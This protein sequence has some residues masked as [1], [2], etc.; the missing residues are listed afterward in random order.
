MQQDLPFV[1]FT[2]ALTW[3][4]IQ[5]VVSTSSF[6]RFSRFPETTDSYIKRKQLISQNYVSV[7][8]YVRINILSYPSKVDEQSGKLKVSQSAKEL[9]FKPVFMLNEF[10]YAVEDGVFHYV[11]WSGKWISES[12]ACVIVDENLDPV[13]WEYV[14]CENPPD[15]RTV[16]EVQ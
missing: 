9:E 14:I 16:P 2:E 13:E 4:E 1:D 11:V 3:F 6:T 12:D 5:S 15:R 10:P 8:D 7:T